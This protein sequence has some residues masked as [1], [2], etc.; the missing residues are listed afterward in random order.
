MSF[1]QEQV[2]VPS[3]WMCK[4]EVHRKS[5]LISQLQSNPLQSWRQDIILRSERDQE[6]KV[7]SDHVSEV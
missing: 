4:K 1:K 2:P 7:E 5:E 3:Q 6:P